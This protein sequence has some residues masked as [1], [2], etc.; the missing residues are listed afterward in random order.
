MGHGA[1]FA[2]DLKAE[3][4]ARAVG[5]VVG[6]A[7]SA[8]LRLAELAV[9]N[10]TI[11]RAAARSVH[12]IAISVEGGIGKSRLA[13]EALRSAGAKRLPVAS[14]ID[15]VRWAYPRTRA[16]RHH[17]LSGLIRR[18]GLFLLTYR[19]DGASDQ[20]CELL[21]APHREKYVGIAAADSAADL[22]ARGA[23]ADPRRARCLGCRAVC[24]RVQASRCRG[25]HAG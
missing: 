18:R 24:R 8:P 4:R 1:K 3:G 16:L 21:R 25:L 2:S 11:G 19:A 5:A 7:T 22:R 13:I 23:A 14:L 12:V 9:L 10:K 6:I 15:D 20:L 17:V